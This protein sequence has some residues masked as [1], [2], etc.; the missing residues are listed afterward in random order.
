MHFVCVRARLGWEHKKKEKHAHLSALN[1]IGK[2][3][4][5]LLHAFLHIVSSFH[6]EIVQ[7]PS[8]KSSDKL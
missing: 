7:K 1:E 8:S 4:R 3:N 6:A 5:L 2:K